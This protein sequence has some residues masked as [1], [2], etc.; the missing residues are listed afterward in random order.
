[1]TKV[2]S[3]KLNSKKKSWNCKS[4]ELVTIVKEKEE[5]EARLYELTKLLYDEFCQRPKSLRHDLDVIQPK[6]CIQ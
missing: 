3:E 6:D 1:V 5:F 2:T 4:V